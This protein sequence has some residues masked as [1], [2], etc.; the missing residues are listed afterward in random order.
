MVSQMLLSAANY[1]ILLDEICTTNTTINWQKKH[2]MTFNIAWIKHRSWTVLKKEIR[3][4]APTRH[5]FP[6]RGNIQQ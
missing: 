5:L 6:N 3:D 1:N 2:N 4:T